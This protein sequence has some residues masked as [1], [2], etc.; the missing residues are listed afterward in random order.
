[1]INIHI[2]NNTDTLRLC[3]VLLTLKIILLNTQCSLV[4]LSIFPLANV[5]YSEIRVFTVKA[6]TEKYINSKFLVR[7][8]LQNK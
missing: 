7:A 8:E 6:F 1:M 3:V 5:Y 2:R 4:I